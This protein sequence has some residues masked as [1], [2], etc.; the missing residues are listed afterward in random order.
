MAAKGD[1]HFGK[2]NFIQNELGCIT[3]KIVKTWNGLDQLEKH[4][5]REYKF[6][7]LELNTKAK[8]YGEEYYDEENYDVEESQFDSEEEDE[9]INALVKKFGKLLK[10]DKTITFGEGNKFVKKDETSP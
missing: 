7:S 5:G 3:Q 10:R 9:D 1:D 2:E 8:D 4:E 6:R